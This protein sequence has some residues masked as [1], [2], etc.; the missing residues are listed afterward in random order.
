MFCPPPFGPAESKACVC[1]ETSAALGKLL[2]ET[3]CL[4]GKGGKGTCKG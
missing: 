2:P 4:E 1:G 3:H